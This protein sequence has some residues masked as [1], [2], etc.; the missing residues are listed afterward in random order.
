M[1]CFSP[2]QAM[3]VGKKPNGKDVIK[4]FKT[5]FKNHSVVHR[6]VELLIPCG[7]CVGCR[8]ERSRQWAV[9]CVHE[10]QMYEHNCFVTLTFN[11]KSLL[12][13]EFPY[14]LDV[15]D[16]QLFMKRL[17]KMFGNGIRFYH[18][19]EYGDRFSRPH[20]HACL[21][22]FTFPDLVFWKEVNGFKLYTSEILQKL[23]PYGYSSVGSVTFE[24]AAYVARYI[25]KKING[26][27]SSEMYR[28]IDFDTGETYVRKKE[29][30]TMSRRPGVG[31]V[32]FDKY[33]MVDTYPNDYV[34]VRNRKMRPPKYYDS[35]LPED[36]L[37]E[38]KANRIVKAMEFEEDQSPQRLADKAKVASAKLALFSRNVE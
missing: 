24:S 28:V 4:I 22:N 7:Q 10:S 11:N 12:E 17:R 38:L 2:L 34:V 29:Y 26:K 23:W 9:R 3:R 25:M 33:A 36:M 32:W 15:R 20:Y 5:R 13:R 27:D 18:C 35:L 30:T 14:S 8:L 1:P 31:S 19:G 37:A 6:D 21:F 16:F